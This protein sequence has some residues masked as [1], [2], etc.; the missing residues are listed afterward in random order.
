[1]L[2]SWAAPCGQWLQAGGASVHLNPEL[3]PGST[4]AADTDAV[5]GPLVADGDP[6]DGNDG[7]RARYRIAVRHP[8]TLRYPASCLCVC[9]CVCVCVFV[10]L[11]V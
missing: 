2:A 10:C 11:C 9:V 4:A 3:Q 7:E 6:F 1:V 5:G 8:R